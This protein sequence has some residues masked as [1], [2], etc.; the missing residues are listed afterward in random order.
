[1]GNR[2][3]AAAVFGVGSADAKVRA[4]VR[5]RDY[6]KEHG[7]PVLIGLIAIVIVTA[8]MMTFSDHFIRD[9][10]IYFYL[11]PITGIAIYYSS[12]PALLMSITAIVGTAYLLFPPIFS[13]RIDEPLQIVELFLF[14]MLALIASKASSRLLR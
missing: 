10:L 1:M 4:R 6:L 7:I 11:F 2:D 12:T 3:P 9:H 8:I 14:S 13:L 5:K